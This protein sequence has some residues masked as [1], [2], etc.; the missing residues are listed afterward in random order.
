[1]SGRIWDDLLTDIDR[2][3]YE[4]AGYGGR[5]GFGLRPA[6]LIVDLVYDFTGDRPEPILQSIEKFRNSCGEV[7][8]RALPRIQELLA[9]ARPKNLPIVYTHQS[10]RPARVAAIAR[11]R[12]PQTELSK[13]IGNDFPPE[14]APQAGDI[15][16]QKDKPSAFFGT[17]LHGFL[18]TL[19]VDSVIIGGATTSGCVRGTVLDAFSLGYPVV[20]AEECTFDR[21][22]L[23]HKVNLFDMHAKNAQVTPLSEVLA[24]LAH[25]PA[26]TFAAREKVA[27]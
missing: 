23:S 2:E 8:W 26:D 4:K 20:V 1:M 11:A 18:T 3:V 13:R 10:A 21:S 24:F 6:L 7:A 9:A 25:L 5:G 17:P 12:V 27:V 14:V 19:H 16:I 15:V 22:L